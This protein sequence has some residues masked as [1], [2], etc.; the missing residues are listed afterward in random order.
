MKVLAGMAALLAAVGQAPGGNAT[1]PGEV[2]TPYP[3][4]IHLAVEWRVEGDDNLDGAVTVRYRAAGETAWRQGPPLRRI[5]ADACKSYPAYTWENK[6]SGTLFDL[7][8]DTEYE[9]RLT[10]ADPDGGSAERTVR[11]RT[12]AVPRAMPGA[13]ARRARPETLKEVLAGA[14]PGD[15]VLLE[16]GQYGEVIVEKDGAPQKP[17]V[18]RSAGGA[19]LASLALRG[20]RHVIV[21]GLAVSDKVDLTGA[22]DCA[23]RRCTV[24]ISRRTFG[25]GAPAKPGC[26]NC[27]ITDNV[28]TG[29]T[30]WTNEAMG[31]RGK[32][33]G[34][35]IQVTGPGNVIACNRVRGFRDCISTMESGSVHNQVC[36]DIYNNDIYVGADDGIEAD[37]CQGNCRILRN[38]LT[39]CFTGLSSQPG[40]GG[41]TYF[42]RNVMYNLTYAAFKLHNYSR[43]DLV[44][45]N[46]VV[47]PGDGLSCFT[48]EAFDRAVFRNNLCIG[49]PAGGVRW[50]GY[51]GGSGAP[52]RIR[53]VGPDSSFDFDALGT[54]G[55]AFQGSIGDQAFASF[56]ELRRGPQ[57]RHAVRADMGVFAGVAFPEAPLTEHAP[58]DLRPRAG[59][60]VVDKAERLPGINDGFA[61]QGPDI[62]AYEA[63]RPLPHYG[64]RPEGADEENMP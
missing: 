1:V 64:P 58:P 2:T 38:R 21:E 34:E 17:L 6:H 57:E 47:K 62:G 25:I 37:Y 52:A 32:N 43:G 29:P 10:L 11:A 63:G 24:T 19:V 27:T 54:H 12:R 35:G 44:L 13:P 49:G 48:H 42:L 53:A 9:V 22:E 14:R 45:H 26:T 40:L 7:R 15:V 20:R 60:A 59:S 8:P 50:G 33:A 18:I 23:V 55:T 30:P 28:V 31:A 5:P 3:T 61:G 46:T 16:A 36:I 41:P 56:E 39:N 51:G 4:L